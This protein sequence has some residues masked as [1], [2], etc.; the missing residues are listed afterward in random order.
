MVMPARA[1]DAKWFTDVLQPR[2]V[3][4]LSRRLLLTRIENGGGP[5]TPVSASTAP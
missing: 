4:G 2:A 1:A 3:S 5:I